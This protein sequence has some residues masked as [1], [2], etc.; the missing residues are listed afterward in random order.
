MI[1]DIYTK[2]LFF[3]RRYRFKAEA[4]RRKVYAIV[5]KLIRLRKLV[6]SWSN[7]F[8]RFSFLISVVIVIYLFIYLKNE[9]AKL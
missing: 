2:S 1:D 4:R 5:M 6:V 3:N 8:F 7:R 9:S